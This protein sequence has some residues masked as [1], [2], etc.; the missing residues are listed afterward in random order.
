MRFFLPNFLEDLRNCRA[1]PRPAHPASASVLDVYLSLIDSFMQRLQ[2]TF[3]PGTALVLDVLWVWRRVG[4]SALWLWPLQPATD[5][6][7]QSLP[8]PA[9]AAAAQVERKSVVQSKAFKMLSHWLAI[10]GL[11][12]GGPNAPRSCG[13]SLIAPP[14]VSVKPQRS[15]QRPS[16]RNDQIC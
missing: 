15:Q 3:L 16:P 12:F 9:D 5:S 8:L 6:Q 1:P 14:V 4:G 7:T 13:S 2:G 11:A 10:R